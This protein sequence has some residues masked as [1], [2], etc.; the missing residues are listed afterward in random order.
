[1]IFNLTQLGHNSQIIS[2]P[3]SLD[4]SQVDMHGA[5]YEAVFIYCE[6]AATKQIGL[7]EGENTTTYS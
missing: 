7:P 5:A 1:L 3:S 2:L 6:Y 4:Y